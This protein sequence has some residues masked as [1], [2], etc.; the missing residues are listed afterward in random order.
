MVARGDLQHLLSIAEVLHANDAGVDVVCFLLAEFFSLQQA[1]YLLDV[2]FLFEFGHFLLLLAWLARKVPNPM[3]TAAEID[4]RRR[5][6]L[7]TTTT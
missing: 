1:N 5:P 2:S 3:A 4:L 6:S 7:A